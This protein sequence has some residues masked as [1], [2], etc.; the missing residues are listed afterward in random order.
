MFA[1]SLQQMVGAWAGFYQDSTPAQIG[2]QFLHIGGLVGSGGLAVASDRDLVR[3]RRAS[4][5]S[6]RCTWLDSTGCTGSFSRVSP[7]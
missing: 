2:M 6:V 3:L 5:P 1:M 4:V 7:S